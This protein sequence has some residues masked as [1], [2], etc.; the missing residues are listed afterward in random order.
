[1]NY[2]AFIVQIFEPFQNVLRKAQ[3]KLEGESPVRQL[4]LQTWNAKAENVCDETN[5]L[6]G[7]TI[8]CKFMQKVDHMLKPMVTR[9]CGCDLSKDIAFP[10]SSSFNFSRCV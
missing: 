8:K 4:S 9:R 6:A 1:M 2:L 7:K 10:E 5:V 3:N